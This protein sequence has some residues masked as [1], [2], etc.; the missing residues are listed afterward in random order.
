MN[1][2]E[3]FQDQTD[4]LNENKYFI[5]L[6]MIMVNIGSR[7]IIDELNQEHINFIKNSYFRR[8]V[9][10]AVIFMA[11]R[12]ILISFVV[13]GL[14]VILV[15]ETIPEPPKE[16][17]EGEGGEGGGSSFAKKELEKEIDKLKIIRDSL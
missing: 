1:L 7:F 8:I 2:V 16:G 14:F 3:Y 15:L 17:E 5:G 10:F 4:I 6:M 13:T 12:D 9:I 11:T